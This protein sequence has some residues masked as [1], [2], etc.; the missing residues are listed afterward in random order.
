[1]FERSGPTCRP[2]WPLCSASYALNFVLLNY[3]I[4]KSEASELEEYIKETSVHSV[5]RPS[6]LKSRPCYK[7]TSF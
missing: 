7:N 6:Y 4:F 3:K 1:V 2:V 5:D